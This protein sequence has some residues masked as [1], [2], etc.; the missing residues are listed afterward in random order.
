[1]EDKIK[2]KRKIFATGDSLGITIP[3]EIVEWLGISKG[4]EIIITPDQ[5]K[6]DKFAAIFKEK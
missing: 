2:F 3:I 4:D 5:G 1:M 6:H